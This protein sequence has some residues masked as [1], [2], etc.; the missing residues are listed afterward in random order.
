MKKKDVQL[1]ID[2]T[3]FCYVRTIE[4]FKVVLCEFSLMEQIFPIKIFSR[5]CTLRGEKMMYNRPLVTHI[6]AM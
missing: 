3:Y 6:Y 1:I 2:D 4:V 5:T